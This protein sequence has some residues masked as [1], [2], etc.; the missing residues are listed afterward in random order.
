M[1]RLYSFFLL[2]ALKSIT[3]SQTCSNHQIHI[4]VYQTLLTEQFFD[5]VKNTDLQTMY[6]ELK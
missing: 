3:L 5:I 4:A 1:C 6:L 2:N